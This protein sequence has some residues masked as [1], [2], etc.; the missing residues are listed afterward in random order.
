MLE[1]EVRDGSTGWGKA[2]NSADQ[3]FLSSLVLKI[4]IAFFV[5]NESI[6]VDNYMFY[7]MIR[8]FRSYASYI[9]LF[10]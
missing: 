1:E 4:S 2:K 7:G 9:K 6:I 5:N 3:I 10:V 8:I